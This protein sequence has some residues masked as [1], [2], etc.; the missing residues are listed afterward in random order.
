MWLTYLLITLLTIAALVYALRPFFRSPAPLPESPRPDELRGEVELLKAQAKESEGEERKRILAQVVRL[1]RELAEMGNLGPPSPR[2]LNPVTLGLA[3][4]ALAAL[5]F[6]LV[7][8]TVPR[9]P[10]ETII[11]ARNEAREMGN[12]E[13]KAKGSGKLEDWEAFA[14]KAWELKD[15][16]RASGAYLQIIKL[17]KVNVTAIRRIGILIFMSGDAGQAIQFL[18]I[19]TAA[20]PTEPE[21]WLFLGNAYFQEGNM[22]NAIQAWQKYIGVGGEAKERVQTLI[23]TAQAQLEQND[24]A[25]TGESVYLKK[26]AA[27]HGAQAQGGAGPRL[28]GNPLTKTPD[29]LREI[30]RNGGTTMPAVPMTD[31]EMGLLLDFLKGL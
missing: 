21:G 27:C 5:G 15:Y 19:A 11:T 10:G 14:D 3:S 4:L 12:L 9:L 26:C 28:K 2:K 29:V 16:E 31:Q 6:G 22:K 8:F 23:Q 7:R 18:N 17:D 30:I 25:P 1:E 13:Q 24:V 20:G